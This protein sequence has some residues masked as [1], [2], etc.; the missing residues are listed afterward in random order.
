MRASKAAEEATGHNITIVLR[1]G[2]QPPDSFGRF[3]WSRI[4]KIAPAAMRL[5][6]RFKSSP[7][8]FET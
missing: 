5:K 4:R 3:I 2:Q 6:V 1:V 8:L 7:L